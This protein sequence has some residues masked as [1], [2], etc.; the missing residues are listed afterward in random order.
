M[1][2][3]RQGAGRK[4]QGGWLPC[5]WVLGIIALMSLVGDAEGQR[6]RSVTPEELPPNAVYDGRFTFVRIR[7]NPTSGGIGTF[8]WFPGDQR[9]D[10]DYPRGER[11]FTKILSELTT[12]GPRVEETNIL[13]LDDPD[14]FK[15]P[16]A[17]LCEPGSWHPTDPEI[18]GLRAYLKK[19]GFL[20]FDDFM[21]ND[22][23]NLEAQLKRVLPESQII[24]IPITHPVFDSFYR[25]ESF[26][27]YVHPYS[28][29]QTQFLGIFENNDPTKRLMV[30][31]NYNGD[32]S[33]YWEFSDTGAF[34]IDL[35]NEA[36]KLGVNYVVYALTR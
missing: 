28:G 13:T 32:M 31:I 14:L 30:A 22:I 9:W 11:H 27:S 23:V 3:K 33:E 20:I 2:G 29:A 8:G 18:A 19:G 16:V 34:P 4:A 21:R 12:L 25:I 35:S 1:G 24:P 7:Y 10:H 26:E 36:Y 15:F 5:R 17:Y 6:R